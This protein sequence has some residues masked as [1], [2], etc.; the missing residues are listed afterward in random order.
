MQ[1]NG[2]ARFTPWALLLEA[3][4]L[5]S[6]TCSKPI[7][8]DNLQ[9]CPELIN[10][11]KEREENVKVSPSSIMRKLVTHLLWTLCGPI[12]CHSASVEHGNHDSESKVEI[13]WLGADVNIRVLRFQLSSYSLRADRPLQRLQRPPSPDWAYHKGRGAHPFKVS[14]QTEHFRSLSVGGLSPL[15]KFPGSNGCLFLKKAYEVD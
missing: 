6:S 14:G 3:P 2:V 4:T 5:W 10:R 9:A 11:F 1:R 8:Y 15:S 7:S 13:A 12:D